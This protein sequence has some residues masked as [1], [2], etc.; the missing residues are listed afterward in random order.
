M[1]VAYGDIRFVRIVSD[2]ASADGFV[3]TAGL[4]S[5]L[6][7]DVVSSVLIVSRL[8]TF[9]ADGPLARC[10]DAAAGLLGAA[11]T[12]L[13]IFDTDDNDDDDDDED[14][15]DD[16]DDDDDDECLDA[17]DLVV[18]VNVLAVCLV[19]GGGGSSK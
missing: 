5:S 7:D 17:F 12:V 18:V 6:D 2:A 11:A 10:L 14:E 3:A 16:D 8:F 19:F 1:C 4:S 9:I 13:I 15:E